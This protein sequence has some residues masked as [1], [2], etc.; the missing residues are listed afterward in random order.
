MA[1]TALWHKVSEKEKQ[2]I[3]E[4]AKII[5]DH[6]ANKLEKIKIKESHFQSGDGLR[7]EGEPWKTPEDFSATVFCNAPD[8]QDEFFVAEKGGWK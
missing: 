4:D 5:L 1:E 8:V 7:D 3:K 2:E 6:F